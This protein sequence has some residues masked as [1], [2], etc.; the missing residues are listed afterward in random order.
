L[1]ISILILF[2]L[3]SCKPQERKTIPVEIKYSRHLADTTNVLSGT[4]RSLELEYIVWGCACA[5][6]IESKYREDTTISFVDSCFFL[7]SSKN[8]EEDLSNFDLS[9]HKIQVVG[10]FYTRPDYPNWLVESEEPISKSRVF[11]YS[12]LKI[13]PK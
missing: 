9:R 2:V 7:E 4:T 3:F 1:K 11:R 8:K 5:P 12:K 10:Q 13:V 6:W